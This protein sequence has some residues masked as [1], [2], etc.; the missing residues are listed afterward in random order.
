MFET[1]VKSYLFKNSTALPTLSPSFSLCKADEDEA[2]CSIVI[3]KQNSQ[4]IQHPNIPFTLRFHLSVQ[5]TTLLMTRLRYS[6]SKDC[7]ISLFQDHKL[8]CTFPLHL[9]FVPNAPLHSFAVCDVHK[10]FANGSKLC[11]SFPGEM[12]LDFPLNKHA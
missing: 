5:D 2:F 9:Y 3:H 11:T 4:A 6:L 10:P 8:F 12:Q 7:T 1:L